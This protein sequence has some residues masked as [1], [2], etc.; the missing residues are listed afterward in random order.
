MSGSE[1]S[2]EF[3]YAGAELDVFALAKNWKSYF[4]SRIA[5]AIHGDV[6]E[7]GAGIGA[8]T[9]LLCDGRQRSWTALEP[10]AKLADRLLADLSIGQPRPTVTVIVRTLAELPAAPAYDTILYIDVLEHIEDDREEMIRAADRLRPGGDLIV[11]S[12]A[13]QFL[14]SKFDQAIG[15][16]RRYNRAM[17]RALTPPGTKL[18]R[19]TYLD[20]VG[21][22]ASL[23]NRLLLRS[24]TPTRRQVLFWDRWLVPCSRLADRLLWGRVGKSIL[25]IWRKG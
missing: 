2:N 25:G 23:A 14:F 11:L 18:V 5:D 13:H 22:L 12:P 8:T 24:A 7:V 19:L 16:Y 9:R 10:D 20:S 17:Y 15:H 4:R 1:R 21:M 3:A 6:L